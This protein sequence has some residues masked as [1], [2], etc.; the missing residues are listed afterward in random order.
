[1][2]PGRLLIE[3]AGED[4]F[5]DPEL[6][7]ASAQLMADDYYLASDGRWGSQTLSQWSGYPG[8]LYE[9][10]LLTDENGDPLSTEPDWSAH[11]DTEI[12]EAARE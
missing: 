11:F 3:T 7:Y 9:N 6:V 10:G 12:I 5:P 2:R 4:A 1:M 8:W